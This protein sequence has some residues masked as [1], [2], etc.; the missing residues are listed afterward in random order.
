MA[1][2]LTGV[3]VGLFVIPGM[4]WAC[5]LLNLKVIR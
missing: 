2:F 4:A 5:G 3:F 1:T